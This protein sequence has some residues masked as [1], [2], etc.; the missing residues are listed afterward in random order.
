MYINKTT[1]W[2]ENIYIKK[3]LYKNKCLCLS[4]H[5]KLNRVMLKKCDVKEMLV[6]LRM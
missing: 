4:R 5:A 6:L 1:K 2:E 3:H